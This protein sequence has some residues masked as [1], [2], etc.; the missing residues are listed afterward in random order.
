MLLSG[1]PD[2][3]SVCSTSG[4]VNGKLCFPLSV[5]EMFQ[6]QVLDSRKHRNTACFPVP[7]EEQVLAMSPGMV[8]HALSS[9]PSKCLA[10]CPVQKNMEGVKRL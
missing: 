1:E 2:R 3:S 9:P 8:L 10:E 6:E 7:A 5:P 4:S